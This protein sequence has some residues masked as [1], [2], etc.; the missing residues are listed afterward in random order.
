MLI[1][2]WVLDEE[3]SPLIPTP[4]ERIFSFIFKINEF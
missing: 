4:G 1:P 2:L 3:A